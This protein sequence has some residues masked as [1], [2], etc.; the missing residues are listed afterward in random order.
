[1]RHLNR[2]INILFCLSI[3]AGLQPASASE[4]PEIFVQLG[5][6]NIVNSVTFS[7]DGRYALSSGSLDGTMRIWDITSGK[8]IAQFISFTD[9]EWLVITPEGYSNA[10]PNGA[11]HLNVRV[12]MNVYSI[13]NFYEK[14]FNPVYVASVLQGKKV[15]A[16]ADIR[17]GVLT[18][19]DVKIISPKPNAYFNTDAITIT[20]SAKDT[21]GGIDEI[22][23][24]HMN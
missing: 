22:K 17:K 3:F 8:E 18:P 20:I 24:Y 19:P 23:L 16:V 6:A 11:K 15:E 1:M 13:D 5:H 7:P 4:K 10:S 14:F 21:G 2:F 9:G 12:G